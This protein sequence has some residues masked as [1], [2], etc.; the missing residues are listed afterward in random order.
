MGIA[1][2]QFAQILTNIFKSGN[3]IHLFK[4]M[5]DPVTEAGGVKVSGTG[6]TGYT[7]KDGDFSV[8]G[9]QATSAKNMLM[10]LC[11]ATGGHGIATGFGI[12]DGGSLL[13][14]GEFEEPMT[15]GYNTVPTI[16]RYN[17]AGE[18]VRVTLTSVESS[19]EAAAASA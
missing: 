19:G 12:Y 15:I 18:G 13:Y 10:Y 9:S 7:I 3:T 16:K 6:Y 11:E 14:F 4:T 2:S 1:K 8:S 5:P 17:G